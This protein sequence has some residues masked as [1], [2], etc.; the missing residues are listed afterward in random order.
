MHNSLKH[1]KGPCSLMIVEVGPSWTIVL[2]AVYLRAMDAFHLLFNHFQF[3]QL[4]IVLSYPLSWI[5]LTE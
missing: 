3:N 5:I 2:E 4:R 1:S